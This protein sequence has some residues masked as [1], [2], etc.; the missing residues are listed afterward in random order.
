MTDE[1]PRKMGQIDLAAM[2][3]PQPKPTC[4]VCGGK[5]WVWEPHVDAP[6]RHQEACPMHCSGTA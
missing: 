6:L 3:R 2:L 5:G 4:R 1:A